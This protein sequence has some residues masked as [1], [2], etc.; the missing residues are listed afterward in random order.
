LI[1]IFLLLGRS[2]WNEEKGSQALG[3]G[4]FQCAACG[5]VAYDIGIAANAGAGY[6]NFQKGSGR[7]GCFDTCSPFSKKLSAFS[8]YYHGDHPRAAKKNADQYYNATSKRFC[9]GIIP[10]R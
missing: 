10:T 6:V 4:D 3:K 7:C 1:L 9:K 5:D 2:V 8:F